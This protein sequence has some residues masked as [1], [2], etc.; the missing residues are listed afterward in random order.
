[1][2]TVEKRG[3]SYRIT[4]AAGL[5]LSG[6]Q[7]RRRMTWKPDE[8]MTPRQIE[9]ELTRQVVRFEEQVRNGGL[10]A[11]ASIRFAEFAEKYMSEYGRQNLKPTTLDNYTRNLVRINQALG[12]I[13]L[14]DLKPLHIQAFVN[15]LMEE[16]IRE[17]KTATGMPAL[18]AWIRRCGRSLTALSKDAGVARQTL[19]NAA[20]GVPV[21]VSSAKKISALIGRPPEALFDIHDDMTPLAPATVH[22]YHRTLS[23]ILDR[24]VLWQIIPSNPA[25]R[26]ALPS[27]SGRKA[28]YLDEPDAKRMLELLQAEPIKWRA[29]IVFDLLSG[30]RRAE[31]LGLRWGDVDMEA[32]TIRIVQTSNY[33]SG[34]G[35]YTG[36]PKTEDSVRYLRISQT[37]VQI[38]LEYKAW[39]DDMRDKLGDAWKGDPADDRI[40]TGETGKPVFPT[41]PTQWMRKF[42]QRTGLASSTVHTLRHTYASLL[43]ADG[44]PLVVVA[45]NLGHAQ[46]STTNNI[47]AHVIAAS[48]AKA[49]EVIDRFA[50]DIH[51]KVTPAPDSQGPVTKK[52][53][54]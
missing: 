48:E 9:K 1:M 41:S 53:K 37:A 40:F 52:K 14:K 8:K 11:D 22:A 32:Q 44:T 35:V 42:I 54:P 27:L 33:V 15:N 21:S 12:H 34:V 20:N 31:L 24:A 26:T 7:I 4:V 39:Q 18:S 16:G 43:I 2:A 29:L 6:K 23:S 38:L 19:S 36:T 28:K 10:S 3:A 13:R 5:D 49:A 50:E 51:P 25:E 30:L 47:Y 17:H 45:N 46:V